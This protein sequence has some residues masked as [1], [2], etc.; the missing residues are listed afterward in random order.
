MSKSIKEITD[1]IDEVCDKRGWDDPPMQLANSL[2]IEMGELA[3]KFEKRKSFPEFSKKEKQ[4]V[5]YEFVDVI[6]YLF[7][8]ASKSGINIE[9]YF[10]KK[11]PK[12]KKKFPVG[13]TEAG[14]LKIKKEYRKT[15]KN[16]L[17]K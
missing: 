14:N 15:G 4:E 10:D 1:I 13:Q 7:R 16:R 17:Y 9:Y 3:Q 12:L 11:L 6:I 2:F 8:F 5:G